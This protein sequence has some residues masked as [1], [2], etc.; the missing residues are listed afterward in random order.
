MKKIL[1]PADET[2]PSPIAGRWFA[3]FGLLLAALFVASLASV[4]QGAPS[5]LHYPAATAPR[6]IATNK[7]RSSAAETIDVPSGSGT[8]AALA[9]YVAQKY[10]PLIDTAFHPAA[11]TDAFYDALRE[12]ERLAVAVN[13]SR[14]S[15]DRTMRDALP[16]LELALARS[17]EQI[18]LLLH[19]TDFAAFEVLKDSDVEQFQLD[20]YAD[21]VANVAPLD[22]LSRRAVLLTKLQHKRQFRSAL[23]DSGILRGDLN[24]AARRAAFVSVQR[25]FH[26]YTEG[27]LQEA[28][29]YLRDDAQYTLLSNYEST[30]FAAELEKL[31]AI[32]Y[33]D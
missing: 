30:E 3:A 2:P 8:D 9:V 13:T 1:D 19:P 21:G 14:Q 26:Q 33:G 23:L 6:V 29:Q 7:A 12:R 20:D 32:A 10:A 27:Y 18:G 28:R 4:N 11:L 5:E 17:D 22:E 16:A 31:R 25:A 24:P 15:S